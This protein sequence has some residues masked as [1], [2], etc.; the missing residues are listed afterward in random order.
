MT[1][2]R[3]PKAR[4]IDLSVGYRSKS[5]CAR[6]PT[7]AA[8][9]SSVTVPTSPPH[10]Q[11]RDGLDIHQIGGRDVPPTTELDPGPAPVVPVIPYDVGKDRRVNDDQCR[12]RSSA[13]SSAACCNPTRPPLRRSMPSSTWSDTRPLRQ[14]AQLHQRV[15]LQRLSTLLSPALQGGVHILRNIRAR[16]RL[17]CLH[18]AIKRRDTQLRRR[19]TG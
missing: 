17:A 3:S 13:R 16:A 11:H 5:S 14:Q 10:T 19:T 7:A 2:A 4:R 15:L 12:C 8:N 18:Y 1:F 6:S 9:R